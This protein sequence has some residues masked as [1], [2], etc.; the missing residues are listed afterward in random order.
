M[1]INIL[2]PPLDANQYGGPTWRTGSILLWECLPTKPI[3][4]K[5]QSVFWLVSQSRRM[6]AIYVG[7]CRWISLVAASADPVIAT[8]GEFRLFMAV[9]AELLL[10]IIYVQLIS[11]F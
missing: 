1:L 2:W 7:S 4:A 6:S 11:L 3:T 9:L 10:V 8:T 5:H